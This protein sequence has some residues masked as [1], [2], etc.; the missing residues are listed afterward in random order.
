MLK[1]LTVEQVKEI[2]QLAA[3][4]RDAQDRLLNK[5]KV[6]DKFDDNAEIMERAAGALDTLDATLNNQSLH[7]L[8]ERIAAL[9]DDGRHELMAILWV[10]RGDHV[11]DDWD[12]ALDHARS[13]SDAGDADRIAERASLHDHLMKGLYNLKL[14]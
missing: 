12:E 3:V 4:A 1:R 14:L 13:A 5:M 9:P 2:A 6:V 11:A 7:E 10:G 8:K